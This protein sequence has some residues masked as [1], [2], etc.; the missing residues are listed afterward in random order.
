MLPNYSNVNDQ[1]FMAGSF[2]AGVSSDLSS[3]V[4]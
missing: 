1:S 4:Q 2:M 3:L